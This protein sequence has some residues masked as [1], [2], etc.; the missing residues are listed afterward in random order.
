MASAPPRDDEP[1]GAA[2]LATAAAAA[3]SVVVAIARR[4]T[5]PG[6]AA[7]AEALR[8]RVT[9]AAARN[10][11]TYAEARA[12][13]RKAAELPPEQRDWQIGQAFARAAEQPLELGRLAAD[14]ALLASSIA[15]QADPDVHA[16][17]VV[18]AALAAGVARGAVALVAV[19][20][21]AVPGDARVVEA[22][23]LAE[24]AAHSAAQAAA[25]GA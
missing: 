17:A 2:A 18:A 21:T 14:L 5:E 22:E 24:A 1:F 15:S 16:D 13:R 8:V 4:S 7:Q 23:R 19:N 9:E 25:A 6:A 3:A 20:L 12:A 11:E 10:A